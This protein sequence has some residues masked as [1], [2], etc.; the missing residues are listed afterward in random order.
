[1]AHNPREN[2]IFQSFSQEFSEITP[3]SHFY[4]RT[5][6]FAILHV[7]RNLNTAKDTSLI[8]HFRSDANYNFIPQGLKEWVSLASV[9][10]GRDFR[11][12]INSSKYTSEHYVINT[13][14]L[15][16]YQEGMKNTRLKKMC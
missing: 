10:L 1:M 2:D 11:F 15:I 8:S 6:R 5:R 13:K 9:L 7:V 3:S 12:S 14:S 16:F 4:I